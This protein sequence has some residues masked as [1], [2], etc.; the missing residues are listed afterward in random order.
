MTLRLTLHRGQGNHLRRISKHE[1]IREKKVAWDISEKDKDC[2]KGL[3]CL[4]KNEK[5]PEPGELEG[6][7]YKI[8]IEDMGRK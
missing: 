5:Y 8:K 6:W 3:L 2:T 1:S 4:K 7:G